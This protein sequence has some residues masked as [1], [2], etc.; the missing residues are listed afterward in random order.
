MD[1]AMW[2]TPPVPSLHPEHSVQ[3]AQTRLQQS[4][5]QHLPVLYHGRLVGLLSD[6]DLLAAL[7]S[8]AVTLSVKELRFHLQH[9]YVADIMTLPVLTVPPYTP[10]VEAAKLMQ[11][12]KLDV[13]PVVSARHLVGLFTTLNM[14][15][16]L[17]AL[18]QHAAP[19]GV[20][21]VR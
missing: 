18:L 11:A 16:A 10:L 4:R 8:P 5:L 19:R 1:V 9:L 12:R 13:L 7:P 20:S 21:T 6:R 3:E 14:L 2:M 15:E 17:R